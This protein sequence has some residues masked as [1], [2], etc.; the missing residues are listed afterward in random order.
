MD[1]VKSENKKKIGILG[2]TFDPAHKGH[3]K[4]SRSAKKNLNLI[5]SYGQLLKK[6]HLKKKARSILKKE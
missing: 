1:Q 3:I 2:G 6:I 5:K 4:I